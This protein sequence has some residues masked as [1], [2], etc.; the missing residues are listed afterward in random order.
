LKDKA[1]ATLTAAA[2][3]FVAFGLMGGMILG[4]ATSDILFYLCAFAQ[5]ALALLGARLAV[6]NGTPVFVILLLGAA[7]LR[8]A[9]VLETPSLSGDIYRYVWDGRTIGAGFNPFLHVPADPALTALRDPEQYGLIDKRDYAVTIYPPVAEAIFA[10]VTRISARVFAM[11]LAMV[12]FEA[13]AVL[14]V[15]QLLRRVERPMGLLI[16]YLLHPA[17]IW[18]IAGNGHVDAAMMALL[19]GAFAVGGARRPF[20]AAIPMTLGALV[21]PTGALGLPALWRPYQVGLPLFVLAMAVALYMPFVAAGTGII[22]F[23]PR[24]LEEQGLISGE[25]VFWLAL[26]GKAR[27][28]TPAIA[29]A[30]AALV[31]FAL[32]GLALWTRRRGATD[33]VGGLEGTALLFVALLLAITPTFPWYFLVALPMTLLLG[34]WTPYALA[35]GGFL[36]Y[37]FEADAPPFF[38]RWSLLMGFAVAAAIRDLAQTAS[39]SKP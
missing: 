36:L 31:G 9:F 1:R 2:L 23:L 3:A 5:S 14:A 25:G 28:L 32:F 17:P 37:G 33:L 26:I 13:A 22:G 4:R 8:L 38:G 21:K 35:S 11:K 30:F 29:P 19:Y 7:I 6:R 34:L 15:A 24:Y 12:L 18:E 39:R 20:L 27:L 16:A 10:L